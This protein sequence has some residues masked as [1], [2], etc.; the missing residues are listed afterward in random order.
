MLSLFT[1]SANI[2]ATRAQT[3]QGATLT[4][5][6]GVVAVLFTNGSTIQ[7]APSGLTLGVG[8]RVATVG[9]PALVTFFEGSELELGADTTIILREI[10]ANG[11]EVH[12]SV[13][14]VLGTAVGRVQAFASPNSSYRLQT[15]GGQTVAL[16]RG[17]FAKL[18]V[19][20][21]GSVRVA[22]G[23]CTHVCEI[24]YQG[25][26]LF[27]NTGGK[28]FGIT[29]TGNVTEESLQS[30]L[31]ELD[32]DQSSGNGVSR[33]DDDD[34]KADSSSDGGSDSSGDEDDGDGGSG[35]DKG[36]DGGGGGNGGGDEEDDNDDGGGGGGH[37]HG[38]GGGGD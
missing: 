30:S 10:L 26:K 2:E 34:D 21:S 32:P 14:D 25:K 16:I 33:D 11:T 38:H 36:D 7:P 20:E 37:G 29:S 22:V 27:E 9:G 3:P 31:D 17:S 4:V 13:E 35:G 28:A 12:V 6:S 5:L 15:P 18:T 24:E 1:L 8:D 23:N 19:F